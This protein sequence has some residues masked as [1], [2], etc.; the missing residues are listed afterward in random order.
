MLLHLQVRITVVPTVLIW[1]STMGGIVVAVVVVLV[2]AAAVGVLDT[3]SR[4]TLAE[5]MVEWYCMGSRLCYYLQIRICW[6]RI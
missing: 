6:H 4:A 5:G 2:V 3:R 1:N